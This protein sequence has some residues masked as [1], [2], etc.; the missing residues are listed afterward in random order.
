MSLSLSLSLFLSLRER[1][2]ERENLVL[3]N[4]VESKNDGSY[5]Y[6][7]DGY[8]GWWGADAVSTDY[9]ISLYSCFAL[10]VGIDG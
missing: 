8:G 10:V 7:D 2:R 9:L 1:E 4:Q 6:E 3:L 5:E